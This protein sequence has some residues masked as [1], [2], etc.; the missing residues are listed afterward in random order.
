MA[1]PDHF[2]ALFRLGGLRYREGRI[3]DA[4][5]CF[6]AAA[7]SKPT[8]AAVWFNLAAVCLVLGHAEEALTHSDWALALKPD[9]AEALH[10]RGD[11]LRALRR[12]RE[13]VESYDRALELRPGYIESLNNRAVA[14]ADLG[15]FEEGLQN[16][17]EAIALA[18]G[19]AA[20][21]NSR[22]VMLVKLERPADAIVSCDIALALSPDYVEALSNRGNALKA[23]KRHEEALQCY[24]RALALRPESAEILSN[25]G[26]VLAELRRAEEGLASMENALALKPAYSDVYANR[27]VLLSELGRF[28]EAGRAI[29]QAIALSPRR[30]VLYHMLTESSRL[31]PG[32]PLIEAMEE[33]ARDMTSL[34]VKEQVYLHFA[35][36]TALA[37]TDC[38]RSFK[39][40]RAGNA[41]K[42]MQ[43][44]YD[45]ASV[46]GAM[47]R[48]RDLFTNDLIQSKG[49]LGDPSCAPVFIVGMPR[50]GSTLIEQIL[51]SHPKV[52]G[53]GEVDLFARTLTEFR[54]HGESGVRFPDAVCQ[55]SGEHLRQIGAG[56]VG[57]L[58]RLAP[59]AERITDKMLDNF[60]FAGLIH[61]ALPNA[62][63]IHARRDPVDTCF[64]CFSKLFVDG[65]AYT[66]DL[67]ELGR[68]YC[69][70]EAL[71]AHWRKVLPKGVMLEVQYEN[72]RKKL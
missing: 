68:Y 22:A 54:G 3:A 46:L 13:A 19:S 57:R 65:L 12:F 29:R 39:H 44:A 59:A 72:S 42:R 23:L 58:N 37:D 18:P 30:A 28:D 17:D 26:L 61:L 34:D 9:S 36:A 5:E 40:L 4:R 60:R 15:R 33:L 21:H 14:L 62:R 7:N 70:Y 52:F 56:Y 49:G 10:V 8:D 35:L 66:Y 55:L 24:D 43:T 51:A 63:I 32:E 2:D 20:L 53:A 11:A 31:A 47:E 16:C 64:S 38:E 41:L 48:T 67:S 1:E 69:A 27:A 25:R 6:I 50:S 71:M 45:E